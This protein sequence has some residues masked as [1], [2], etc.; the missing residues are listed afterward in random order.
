[1]YGK[2][3]KPFGAV[4]KSVCWKLKLG[5]FSAFGTVMRN[6]KVSEEANEWFSQLLKLGVQE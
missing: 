6:K 1:L 3:K 5:Y 2:Q 4:V